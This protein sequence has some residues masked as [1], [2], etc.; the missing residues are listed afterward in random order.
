MRG[1][2]FELIFGRNEKK[3][4]EFPKKLRV[5]SLPTLTNRLS[6]S[7]KNEQGNDYKPYCFTF[8]MTALDRQFK[9][10]TIYRLFYQKGRFSSSKIVL[11]G[12]VGQL[13][14]AGR[15]KGLTKPRR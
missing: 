6:F 9:R 1:P 15:G 11:D 13:R 5:T 10:E 12:K 14:L 3:R 7:F 4:R 8:M 2:H